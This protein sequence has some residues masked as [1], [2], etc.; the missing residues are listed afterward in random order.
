MAA[1]LGSIAFLR[2]VWLSE[3]EKKRLEPDKI[4][5]PDTKWEFVGFFSVQVNVVLDRQPLL[6]AGPLRDWLRNI[7][8]GQL[9]SLALHCCAP[10]GLT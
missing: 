5:R 7:A 4:D 10:R 2:R 9:V 6:G 1:T 8:H 3:Q